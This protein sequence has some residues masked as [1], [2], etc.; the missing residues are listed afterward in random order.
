MWRNFDDKSQQLN[1]KDSARERKRYNIVM[2]KQNQNPNTELIY[3]IHPIIELLKAKRRK[4]LNIYT[5]KPEPKAWPEIVKRLPSYTKVAF[6]T[7]EALANIAQTTD[8][9]GVVGFA[10]PFVF[11]KKQFDP[12]REKFLL[13]L[14]GIQ[15]PRNLGAILRTAYCTNVDGVII[16]QRS[17]APLN[18]VALKSSAGLAEH[19]EILMLPSA[20]SGAQSLV[21][22]G[23]ALYLTALHQKSQNALT[24]TYKEPLCI[25]IGSEGTGISRELIALGTPIILPQKVSDI[26]YNASVAAGIILFHVA[27]QCK[28]LQ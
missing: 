18:A 23:Y 9:Q 24:A 20:I 5:T 2:S 14:D 25:C 10:A 8:H 3:G 6:V 11:R 13:L 28:R 21:Q 7:R 12:A 19:L 17:S 4:L 22:Q 1:G 15:D 16:T 27:V 26:S